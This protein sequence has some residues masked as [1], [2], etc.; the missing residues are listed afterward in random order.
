MSP[1]RPNADHSRL[2]PKTRFYADHNVPSGLIRALRLKGVSV[3]TAAER[4]KESASDQEHYS[5]AVR[6][7]R[8]LLTHDRDFLDRRKFSTRGGTGIVVIDGG[9]SDLVKL[10]DVYRFLVFIRR[11]HDD[12]TTTIMEIKT[13]GTIRVRWWEKSSGRDYEARYKLGR[14]RLVE[15][16]AEDE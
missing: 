7:R 6:L 13:D 9:S 14:Y 12:W 3:V 10:V 1:K 16:S 8:I 2:L 15:L 11:G 4:G 5:E